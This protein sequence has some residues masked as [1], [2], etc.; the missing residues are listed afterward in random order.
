MKRSVATV[1]T[2]VTRIFAKLN[3]RNRSELVN[4]MHAEK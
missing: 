2:H 1:K 3:V 4:A